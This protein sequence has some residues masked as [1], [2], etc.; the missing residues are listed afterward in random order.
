MRATIIVLD[1]LGVGALPDAAAYGDS[2]VD[3]LGHIL[4]N[5]P[6]NIPNLRNLGMGN[7]ERPESPAYRRF[8]G[9][10]SR[11]DDRCSYN[12]KLFQN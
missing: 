6:L 2:G 10:D 12:D 4:D 9:L 1:S 7:I 11:A 8:L 3:T 5:Y